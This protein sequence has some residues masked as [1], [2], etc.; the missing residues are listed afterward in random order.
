MQSCWPKN[1]KRETPPRVQ[2]SSRIKISSWGMFFFALMRVAFKCRALRARFEKKGGPK[3][4][5]W[6][7]G[8]CRVSRIFLGTLI[9]TCRTENRPRTAGLAENQTSGFFASGRQ[10]GR[11][12]TDWPSTLFFADRVRIQKNVGSKTPDS[13]PTRKCDFFRAPPPSFTHCAS[14]FAYAGSDLQ[15]F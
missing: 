3:I 1:T 8:L 13:E 12:N 14:H 6:V 9:G 11:A 7:C 5:A 4:S 2:K 15:H 10:A